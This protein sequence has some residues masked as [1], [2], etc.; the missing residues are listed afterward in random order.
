MHG[1]L[2]TLLFYILKHIKLIRTN[3][4][5]TWAFSWIIFNIFLKL[6]KN[7]HRNY[8]IA[9][10]RCNILKSHLKTV[11]LYPLEAWKKWHLFCS[12]SYSIITVWLVKRIL[13]F[14]ANNLISLLQFDF[15]VHFHFLRK[16]SVKKVSFENDF[17]IRF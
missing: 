9:W 4:I 12:K 7:I 14:R 10:L 6:N 15:N 17:K 8:N 16:F 5:I 2:N 1:F 11:R 13:S 3:M